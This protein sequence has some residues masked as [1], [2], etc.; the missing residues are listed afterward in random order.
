MA[1]A[2]APAV[3]ELAALTGDGAAP[4]LALAASGRQRTP[5]TSGA[6]RAPRAA[7]FGAF[8]HGPAGG[9]LLC[10][11]QVRHEQPI[12]ARPQLR[13]FSRPAKAETSHRPRHEP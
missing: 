12:P 9:T 1:R 5:G 6:P 8:R 11:A 3:V 10:L 7:R 2:R 13:R 4:R